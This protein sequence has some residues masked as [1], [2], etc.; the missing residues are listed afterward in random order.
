MSKEY[1]VYLYGA[2]VAGFSV[3]MHAIDHAPI[4]YQ[5]ENGFHYGDPEDS[6]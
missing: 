3:L 2:V 1:I 5:D 6:V 4:G